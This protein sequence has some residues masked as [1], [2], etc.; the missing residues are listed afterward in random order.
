MLNLSKTVD[1]I[2]QTEVLRVLLDVHAA[3]CHVQLT[4]HVDPGVESLLLL[5]DFD[6]QTLH[7][8]LLL[9]PLVAGCC[10]SSLVFFVGCL[11]VQVQLL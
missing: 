10:L 5:V 1:G 9:V 4:H 11:L 6:C 2:V 3:D 7:S 8:L